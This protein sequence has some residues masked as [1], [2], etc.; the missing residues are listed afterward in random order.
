MDRFT[1]GIAMTSARHPWRT[2]A[3]WVL[4]MGTAL[5]L[6]ASGGGTFT[7]DF[8]GMK[9]YTIA[10]GDALTLGAVSKQ[11]AATWVV[12]A[13]L[14]LTTGGHVDVTAQGVNLDGDSGPPWE[15]RF[16]TACPRRAAISCRAATFRSLSSSSGTIATVGTC[17]EISASGPCLS[18][19]VW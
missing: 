4:V 7:D 18:S 14:H 13:T 12:P 16:D 8:F 10:G 15:E 2:V 9:A 1:R 11:S 5:F 6:A 17:S 19:E 3:T